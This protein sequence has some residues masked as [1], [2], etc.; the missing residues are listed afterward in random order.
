MIINEMNCMYFD[1]A[2]EVEHNRL[3]IMRVSLFFCVVMEKR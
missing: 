2:E 1:F 3:L